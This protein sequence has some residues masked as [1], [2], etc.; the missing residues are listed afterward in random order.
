MVAPVGLASDDSVLDRFTGI[1]ISAPPPIH[2]IGETRRL[3]GCT[4]ALSG[5]ICALSAEAGGVRS[6]AEPV[7]QKYNHDCKSSGL[8]NLESEQN[9]NN[10]IIVK[11]LDRYFSGI[12]GAVLIEK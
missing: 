11:K 7:K 1:A 12:S 8:G 5:G 10:L 3:C 6:V 9:Q 4:A 2:I